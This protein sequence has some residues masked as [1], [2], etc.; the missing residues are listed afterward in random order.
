[1]IEQLNIPVSFSGGVITLTEK[2]KYVDI[3]DMIHDVDMLLYKAKDAGR[4]RIETD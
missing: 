2:D 1:V 4:N 3:K